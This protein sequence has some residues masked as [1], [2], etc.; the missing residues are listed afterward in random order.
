MKT[1]F[2]LVIF[3]LLIFFV[4]CKGNQK[5]GHSP[6]ISTFLPLESTNEINDFANYIKDIKYLNLNKANGDPVYKISKII[7]TSEGSF[8][9][10]SS[11]GLC[12]FNSSGEFINSY[13]AKGKGPGEY[14]EIRDYC[15]SLDEKAVLILDPY[16]KILTYKFSDGRYQSTIKPKWKVIAPTADFI[17]PGRNGGFYLFRPQTGTDA[18][19]S[20]DFFCLTEF[21][22][23]GTIQREY[24]KREDFIFNLNVFSQGLNNNYFIRPTE[25]SKTLWQIS[26]GRLQEKLK[27]DFGEKGIPKEHIFSFGKDPWQHVQEYGISP[28]YKLLRSFRETET[29][30]YFRC[31]NPSGYWE[32][33]L[34]SKENLKG[35]RWIGDRILFF[36]GTNDCFITCLEASKMPLTGVEKYDLL[37]N[38]IFENLPK[39]MVPERNP[40]LVF[41]EFNLK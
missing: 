20:T 27:I 37:E 14:M 5:E 10:K 23:N 34:F 16:E 35:I 22:K 29:Q 13:G 32:S 21:D 28:Y 3:S 4:S 30:M 41:I 33:F 25:G 12:H 40:V 19:F 24:L 17:C 11:N 31:S 8:L 18:K 1:V 7:R 26:D 38:Y 15:L 36:N 6:N 2:K 39:E 9:I